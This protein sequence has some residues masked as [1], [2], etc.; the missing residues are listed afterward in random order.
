MKYNIKFEW[1]FIIMLWVSLNAFFGVSV[2][3]NDKDMMNI[4]LL[5]LTNAFSG[6]VGY[7]YGKSKPEQ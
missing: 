6:G 7:I 3:V 2:W 1:I 4:I 5:A